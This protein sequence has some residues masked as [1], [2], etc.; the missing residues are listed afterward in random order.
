MKTFWRVCGF[1]G[2]FKGLLLVAIAVNGF[3][4]LTTSGSIALINLV[5]RVFELEA[6]NTAEAGGNQDS[7][8]AASLLPGLPA[9]P[10]GAAADSGLHHLV[11]D[12]YD[13]MFA[14][15]RSDDPYIV[16]LKLS[17]LILAVFF[18]KNLFKYL[19]A[20]IN[21]R[22]EEGII[23]SIRDQV[24][25]KLSRLSMSYFTNS[26]TG[27]LISLVTNDISQVNR[28]LTPTIMSLTRE[29]IEIIFLLLLLLGHS[30]KLTLI[31]F[32][33]SVISLLLIQ[34]AT[35]YLRRYAA[36]MQNAMAD[37]TTVLQETVSGIKIIKA[38]G[39]EESAVK[40]FFTQ[41]RRYVDS[42]IK[43]RKVI[44]LVP[45]VNEMFAIAALCAVLYVGGGEVFSG[46][47]KSRDLITFL[48]LLFAIMSPITRIVQ[49]PTRIQR[50][51]VAAE[52]VFAAL[53]T[54]PAVKS[55]PARVSGMKRGIEVRGLSFAYQEQEVLR[56]INFSLTRH[57]KIA[58]V[59]PSG[60][61]KSTMAD[62]LIRFYDPQRGAL[63]LD[64]RDIRDYDL[65]SYR[66]LFGVVSQEP[67]LF[68]DS[69]A[70]N[71]RYGRPAASQDEVQRAAEIANAHS[72]IVGMSEGYETTIGDRGVLLSGGQKQ[73]IAI[74]RALLRDPEVLIFDE[75]TSALDSE[76]E[77][78]VQEA[79]NR[80]LK[81][82]TAVIIAHRLSTIIDADE[83]L[84]FSAGRI[85]ERGRHDELISLGGIYK[86][87]CDIQ[88]A[89]V[90]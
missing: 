60:G 29:P 71:I 8:P 42:A 44:A 36:R 52:R 75:A 70:N 5:M 79:M 4:S 77:K 32:S 62:L 61:G 27:T 34:I 24:F 22:L 23:K 15:V 58:F 18:A 59:G 38:F 47:M 10:A 39:L 51:L 66:R 89:G 28:S 65:D 13:Y 84:V 30:V 81:N 74:A 48:F 25:G 31:A 73:R 83:I 72:F 7:A 87:L 90:E 64:D 43:H 40:R 49:L 50:G 3:Y 85:A 67:V 53:D 63:L 46:A 33:T 19:A 6:D 21:V 20:L 35:K 56:D 76:S 37:F 68:N 86:N 78:L 55:G 2:P 17:L 11:D 54:E 16:L 41:T 14:I 9:N 12:F 45:G 82:R 26:K 69:V 1:V 80:V 57:K 88:F